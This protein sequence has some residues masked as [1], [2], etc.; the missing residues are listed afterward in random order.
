MYVQHPTEC[1]L[2][3]RERKGLTILP[4]YY[5]PGATVPLQQ[6]HEQALNTVFQRTGNGGSARGGPPRARRAPREP[7]TW[8][9]QAG[10]SWPLPV[11]WPGDSALGPVPGPVPG[12]RPCNCSHCP[13]P[14]PQPGEALARPVGDNASHSA[15]SLL[16]SLWAKEG[17]SCWRPGG[18]HRLPFL[19]PHLRAEL[20]DP[21]GGM[22][23]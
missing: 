4:T 21:S 20:A 13:H 5:P 14:C 17:G 22:E 12:R 23:W 6:S 2:V 10:S 7:S 8:D 3:H 15:L 1:M 19:A 11:G 9:L 16:L 18:D